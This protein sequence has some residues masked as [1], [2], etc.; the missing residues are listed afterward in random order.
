MY[1]EGGTLLHF[2]LLSLRCTIPF[3]LLLAATPNF[4]SILRNMLHSHTKPLSHFS[5]SACSHSLPLYTV[6][7]SVDTAPLICPQIPFLSVH[8]AVH[9]CLH[10][11]APH[12]SAEE[13]LDPVHP[14]YL[15]SP[16]SETNSTTTAVTAASAYCC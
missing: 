14:I 5:C 12:I 6:R 10:C 3:S 8:C 9:I 13:S 1:E 7:L 15:V 4:I 16:A 2:Q 11:T